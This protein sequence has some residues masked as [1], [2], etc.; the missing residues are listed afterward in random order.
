MQLFD[1]ALVGFFIR[2]KIE[3]AIY[4]EHQIKIE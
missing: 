1:I 4:E 2:C 3:N